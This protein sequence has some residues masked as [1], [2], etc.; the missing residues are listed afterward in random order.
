MTWHIFG[1][2]PGYTAS[3]VQPPMHCQLH[4]IR[5]VSGNVNDCI[6]RRL[7]LSFRFPGSFKCYCKIKA[8]RAWWVVWTSLWFILF[9][10]D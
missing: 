8:E 5:P 4:G 9:Y 10:F 7:R 6:P 1:T 2:E 3:V